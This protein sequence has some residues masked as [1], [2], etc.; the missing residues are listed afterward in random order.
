MS[1]G[2]REGGSVRPGCANLT[3]GSPGLRHGCNVGSGPN[4]PR[5]LGVDR[6]RVGAAVDPRIVTG[7]PLGP[8]AGRAHSLER[9]MITRRALNSIRLAWALSRGKG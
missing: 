7:S 8:R 1:A 9:V 2:R 5:L 6:S 3:V 4:D